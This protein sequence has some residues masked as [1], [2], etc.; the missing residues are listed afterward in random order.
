MLQVLLGLEGEPPQRLGVEAVRPRVIRQAHEVRVHEAL[1]AMEH[2]PQPHPVER[3]GPLDLRPQVDGVVVTVG[4]SEPDQEPA[5]GLDA[6]RRDELAPEHTERH[7]ADQEDALFVKPDYALVGPEL[8]QVRQP[9]VE[10]GP[11][12]STRRRH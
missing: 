1:D 9:E 11:H 5:G 10:V 7:G 8:E 12:C 4:E 2:G 6:D 3:V